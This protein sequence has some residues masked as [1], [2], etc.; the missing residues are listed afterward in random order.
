[1]SQAPSSATSSEEHEFWPE[2]GVPSSGD[3]SVL[4]EGDPLGTTADG[5]RAGNESG[6]GQ[7]EIPGDG[8]SGQT[9]YAGSRFKD[10]E[11]YT[12]RI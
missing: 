9:D 7:V 5:P 6:S 3:Q 11:E 10:D 12:P 8:H 2:V 4:G 1:M